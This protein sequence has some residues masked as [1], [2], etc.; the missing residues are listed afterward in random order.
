[1]ALADN[2]LRA[3]GEL[4]SEV[5]RGEVPALIKAEIGALPTKDEFS[6]TVD[7]VMGEVQAIRQS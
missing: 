5:I 4:I 2:D 1:M 6:S 3:I 7:Q